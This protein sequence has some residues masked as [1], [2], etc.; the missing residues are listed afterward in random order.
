MM[1]MYSPAACASCAMSTVGK[2]NHSAASM[3]HQLVGNVR[4]LT[5]SC[6]EK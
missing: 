5:D 2:S 1:K 4:N 3:T 6:M